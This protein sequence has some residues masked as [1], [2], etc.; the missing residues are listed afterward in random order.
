MAMAAMEA[1]AAM[2]FARACRRRS[3]SAGRLGLCR[4]AFLE[5]HICITFNPAAWRENDGFSGMNN[6]HAALLA[7]GG[8]AAAIPG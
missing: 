8:E 7:F 6:C 2:P 3:F 5:R 4:T 1:M